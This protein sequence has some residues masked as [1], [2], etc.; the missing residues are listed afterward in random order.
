MIKNLLIILLGFI[1]VSCLYSDNKLTD[2]LRTENTSFTVSPSL[3]DAQYA[4]TQPL[5]YVVRNNTIHLDKLF[6]FIGGT[7]SAPDDYAFFL[8]HAG[9]VG[10]DVLSLSYP[11]SVPAAALSNIP[12]STVFDTYRNEICFGSSVSD[13]VTVDTLNSIHTRAVKLLI[14]LDVNYPSQNWGQYLTSE[15]ELNW[16]KIVVGGHSQGAGHAAYFAKKYEVSRVTMFSGPNDY[17]TY[18]SKPAD[19]LTQDGATPVSKFYALLHVGDELVPYSFQV[20]NLRALGMLGMGESPTLSDALAFPFNNANALSV[21]ILSSSNH[22]ST[23][24]DNPLLPKIWTY[25]LV[26]GS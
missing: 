1:S 4:T 17:S 21:N 11:N 12:D 18:F 8:D 23:I 16:S 13:Q 6:L 25:I 15:N 9:K 22:N 26:T 24:G 14:Y 7:D 5:H 20:A 2:E 3:T 10:L 19:W